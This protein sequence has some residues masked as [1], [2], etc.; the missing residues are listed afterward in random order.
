MKGIRIWEAIGCSLQKQHP[1]S[2]REKRAIPSVESLP[3]NAHSKRS[4]RPERRRMWTKGNLKILNTILKMS[5]GKIMKNKLLS[6]FLRKIGCTEAPSLTLWTCPNHTNTSQ[7]LSWWL[8]NQHAWL[9]FISQVYI[10]CTFLLSSKPNPQNNIWIIN[11]GFGI[12]AE[13][14]FESLFCWP[15]DMCPLASGFPKNF[16][17][18]KIRLKIQTK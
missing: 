18:C 10:L 13:L 4:I 9:H 16:L 11:M 17:T 1:S 5:W 15:L 3:W 2:L 12:K 14:G 6:P 7:V 8:C